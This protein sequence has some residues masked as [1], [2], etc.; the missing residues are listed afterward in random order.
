[1]GYDYYY[2]SV[3]LCF[4]VLH[5]LLRRAVILKSTGKEDEGQSYGSVQNE[6]HGPIGCVS[7]RWCGVRT[8]CVRVR[9]FCRAP[10]QTPT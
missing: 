4:S 5:R 3:S 1:M 6:S 8:V 2:A 9:V 10:V 7:V